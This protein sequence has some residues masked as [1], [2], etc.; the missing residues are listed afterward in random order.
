MPPGTAVKA[1]LLLE[2]VDFAQKTPCVRSETGVEKALGPAPCGATHD[3]RGQV[4]HTAH[5]VFGSE[6]FEV[7]PRSLRS[8]G[9]CPVGDKGLWNFAAKGFN[10]DI[11]WGQGGQHLRV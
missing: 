8:A 2:Q 9:G 7:D 11:G 3:R 4:V 10:P 5:P 6:V 1:L